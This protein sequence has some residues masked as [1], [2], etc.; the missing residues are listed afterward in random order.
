MG[1]IKLGFSCSDDFEKAF[2]SIPNDYRE[3]EALDD[4]SLDIGNRHYNYV[5]FKEVKGEENAN[6]GNNK[7]PNNREG[8]VYEPLRKLNSYN[9]LYERI[10]KDFGLNAA[11]L[12]LKEMLSGSLLLN[13]SD[14]ADQRYCVAVSA[15]SLVNKGRDYIRDVP[16][17]NPKHYRSFLHT[18]I[19][20]IMQLSGEF[21]GATVIFD[22]FIYLSFFTK[23][24]RDYMHKEFDDMDYEE[25]KKIAIKDLINPYRNKKQCEVFIEKKLENK[26]TKDL[27]DF[28]FNYLILN[29]IQGYVLILNNKY[30]MASQSP[31]TNISIFSP[32]ILDGNFDYFKFPDGKKIQD[33]MDEILTIQLLFAEFFSKG[34]KGR[35]RDAKGNLTNKK[36]TKLVPFPVVTLAIANDEIGSEHLI[37]KDKEYIEKIQRLFSKHHNLNIFKGLKLALCCRLLSDVVN[38]KSH[39]TEMSSLGVVTHN[40]SFDAVGSLRVLTLGLPNIALELKKENRNL[41][42]YLKLLDKKTNL[43]IDVLKSQRNL[44]IERT[45]AGFYDFSINQGV[46]NE[47][48]ASTIGG[49][50]LY[51][52]VKLLS[53]NKWG[54]MYTQEELDMANEILKFVDNKCQEAKNKTGDIYNME[55]SIPA[56]SS[57]F[58]LR[59][60]DYLSYGGEV[61]YPELSNQFLP[62]TIQATLHEKLK[63]EDELCK[64][65]PSTTIAHINIDAELSEDAVVQLHKKIAEIY[66]N[67]SHYAFNPVNYLCAEGHLHTTTTDEGKCIECESDIID[68]STRSIG[69]IRSIDNEFGKGRK[70]EQSRRVYYKLK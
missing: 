13:D 38:N 61:E 25:Y 32:R 54:T 47:K 67:L 50:G 21:K 42:N 22:S 43:V 62:A 51:E 48:L 11:N 58:R 2:Y 34:I 5:N 28:T 29:E 68:R 53:G 15:H 60:R 57:A 41:E 36:L 37:E 55:L 35:I 63:I 4:N 20:Q 9:I 52:A 44:I 23:P 31:F 27:I 66:P 65:I 49:V 8:V 40:E 10:K 7:N 69:Y 19:E 46:K 18:V 64:Y 16:N 59:K 6:V 70:D 12:S 3:I 24:V 1:T 14:G 33:Y 39:N 17:T 26:T 56:E 45:N 30:R